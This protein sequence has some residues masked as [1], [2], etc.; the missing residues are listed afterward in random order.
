MKI[1]RFFRLEHGDA[2]LIVTSVV[3]ATALGLVGFGMEMALLAASGMDTE[4]NTWIALILA[5]LSPAFGLL[6]PL[7]L[8]RRSAKRGK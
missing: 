5:S 7:Y 8:I 6:L 1:N 3:V 2:L 4:K